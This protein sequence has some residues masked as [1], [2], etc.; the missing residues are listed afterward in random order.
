MRKIFALTAAVAMSVA[1]GASAQTTAQASVLGE[2]GNPQYP[3]RVQGTNGQI[4]SCASEI[5]TVDGVRA[6]RCIQDGD[7]GPLF[8]SGAGLA[9]GGAVAAGALLLVVLAA[10]DGSSSTTTTTTDN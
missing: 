7:A 3:L 9:T 10:N 5:E 2:T 6:R 4:Y 1:A 8:A